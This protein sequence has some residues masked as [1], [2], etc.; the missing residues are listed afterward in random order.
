MCLSVCGSLSRRGQGR[1][2]A[3]VEKKQG[4]K[5]CRVTS[6]HLVQMTNSLCT[7]HLRPV[8]LKHA[9]AGR[10]GAGRRI[11]VT[12]RIQVNYN[13]PYKS[14]ITVGNEYIKI[15]GCS[16]L[17]ARGAGRLR[18]KPKGS[19]SRA[20]VAIK[21]KAGGRCHMEQIWVE[22]WRTSSTKAMVLA[23]YQ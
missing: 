6:L 8:A 7:A 3:Y 11:A 4:E 20:N 13:T 5:R 14:L 2:S 21:C 19:L 22:L 15:A 9:T 23:R 1:T 10:G 12:G 16:P 17:A 18:T